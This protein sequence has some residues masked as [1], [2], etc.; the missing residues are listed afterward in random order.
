MSRLSLRKSI[1]RYLLLCPPPRC[2]TWRRPL[3]SRPEILRFGRVRD[4]SGRSVVR[5]SLVSVVRNRIAG[6]VGLYDLIPMIPL[7]PWRLGLRELDHLLALFQRD[8]RFLPVRTVAAVPPLATELAVKVGGADAGDFHLE[9]FLYGVPD[10]LLSRVSQDL[11]GQRL[12][13]LLHE[14]ALLRDN[15]GAQYF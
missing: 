1:N 3:L 10:F 4:L 5:S 6:E 9:E 12:Q 13:V 2:R 8:V 15:W 14:G 11:E 7:A